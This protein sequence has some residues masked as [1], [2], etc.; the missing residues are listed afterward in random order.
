M[1][2][3]GR[4]DTAVIQY[5]FKIKI[6]IKGTNVFRQIQ[7]R[8]IVKK[9]VSMTRVIEWPKWFYSNTLSPMYTWHLSVSGSTE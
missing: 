5:R 8:S 9:R 3:M 6:H 7:F 4:N 2:V 1:C